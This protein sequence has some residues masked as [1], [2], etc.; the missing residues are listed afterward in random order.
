[1]VKIF[2][3]V[4]VVANSAAEEYGSGQGS[5]VFLSTGQ[6][7]ACSRLPS[8]NI[9]LPFLAKAKIPEAL[10]EYARHPLDSCQADNTLLHH[11]VLAYS[12]NRVESLVTEV[13]W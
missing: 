5:R 8:A 1:M 4:V 10:L 12:P 13:D 9:R 11:Y 3:D 7:V 2:I 6:S